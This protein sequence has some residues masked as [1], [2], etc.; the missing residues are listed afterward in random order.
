MFEIISV[1]AIIAG[2]S[3]LIIIHEV[4]HFTAAKAFGLLVEEFG[5]GLPPRMIGKK[6]GE[7]L[8]SLNWLP[9]GG[10]VR[11]YGERQET[12][13]LNISSIRSLAQQPI[14]KRALVIGAGVGMNIILG[15]VLLSA[16]FA[17]GIPQTLL[18]TDV[19]ENGILRE[20][21]VDKLLLFEP[22]RDFFFCLL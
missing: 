15:W 2:L 14:W 19:V 18:I 16:V 11:I 3:L 12:E 22:E 4:G 17:I 21:V 10:F 6:I 13:K 20:P 9:L 7:T 8:Y 5:F 1:I